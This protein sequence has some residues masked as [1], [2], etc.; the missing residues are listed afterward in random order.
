MAT[1]CPGRKTQTSCLHDRWAA[2]LSSILDVPGDAQ[3]RTLVPLCQSHRARPWTRYPPRYFIL[4]N[5]GKVELVLGEVIV[6]YG[7]PDKLARYKQDL[8]MAACSL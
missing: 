5:T 6:F 1:W 8:Q 4:Q 7:C 2:S 3:Q